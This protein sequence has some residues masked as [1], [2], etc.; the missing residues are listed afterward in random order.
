MT[1]SDPPWIPLSEPEVAGREWQY[2]KQ[3]LDTGWISSVGSFVERFEREV[4]TRVRSPWA[5]ATM[6]GTAALHLAL[7]VAGVEPGDEVLVSDLTFIA[8]A[9]AV[10]YL[11]AWPV[12]LDAEPEHAQLDPGAVAAFLER[13]CER[14]TGGTFDRGTGRRVKALLPVDILGHPVDLDPLLDLC[15]AWE[16]ELVEDAT[17]SLGA[18][19]R[20]A[21]VGSRA[22]LACLSFNGNKL[23]STGGGGMVLTRSQAWADRIRRLST[24]AKDDPVE[25]VHG[26]VG[27]NYRMTN[28]LAA[29]GVA[30]LERLDEYLERKRRIA[31]RYDAALG[32]L[33]RA[34]WAESSHWLYTIR[35]DPDRF[36]LDSRA[37]LRFLEA[38]RIRTRPLWQPM[39]R[40]PAH[41]DCPAGDCPVAERLYRMALSLPCSVGLGEADQERVIAAVRE[42]CLR[43]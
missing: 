19:Y 35:V 21:P 17:E 11:G 38:R 31:R 30:Q 8:P 1:A 40:S 15:A 10:R 18:R 25:S 37:L 39:H 33:G 2:V 12:F 20:G 36:G 4:A 7:K 14:R 23:V 13:R 5:V 16:L 32:P 42:A 6:N 41:R 34:P 26:E 29:I 3:C 22:G 24:Q 9:N 27:Y 28:V 43:A